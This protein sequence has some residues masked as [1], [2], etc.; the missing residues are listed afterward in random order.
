LWIAQPRFVYGCRSGRVAGDHQGFD[1]VMRNQILG[2]GVGAFSNKSIAALAIGRVTTV[3]YI[4]KALIR[5]LGIKACSTLRPPMPLSKT[6][7]G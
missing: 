6:P 2:D 7:M 3:G 5:Q 4:D 1:A